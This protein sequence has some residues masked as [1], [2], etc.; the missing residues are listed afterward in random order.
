[1]STP[2]EHLSLDISDSDDEWIV[3]EA[4]AGGADVLVT[5][6][7]ALHK[8]G[9]R[10]A[11]D[12]IAERALGPVARHR[13]EKVGP[14]SL[15]KGPVRSPRSPELERL[16]GVV[17]CAPTTKRPMSRRRDAHSGVALVALLGTAPGVAPSCSRSR[18]PA[19]DV[20]SRPVPC[21]LA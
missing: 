12:R 21:H 1:M 5:G 15:A 13:T 6:D 18:A 19:E 10:P 3:A 4:V 2:A 7:A 11:A 17:E 20:P 8:L 14:R 9:K 16:M